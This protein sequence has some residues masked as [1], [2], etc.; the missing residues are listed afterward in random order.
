MPS[1]STCRTGLDGCSLNSRM[2][3]DTRVS[4]RGAN[5]AKHPQ[6]RTKKPPDMTHTPVGTEGTRDVQNIEPAAP[7]A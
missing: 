1:Q 3:F 4:Q 2:A 7:K 6:F 5:A